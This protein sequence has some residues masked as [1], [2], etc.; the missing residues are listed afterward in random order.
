MERDRAHR[1]QIL[2]IQGVVY[3]GNLEELNRRLREE[4]VKAALAGDGEGFI[5][6]LVRDEGS[7]GALRMILNLGAS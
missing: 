6:D 2:S 1:A 5:F 3:S 7:V 4:W